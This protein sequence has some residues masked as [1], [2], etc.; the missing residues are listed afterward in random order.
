M[1][2]LGCETRCG[3]S[4]RACA[5][6]AAAPAVQQE[7][8]LLQFELRRRRVVELRRCDVNSADMAT[9]RGPFNVVRPPR[10]PPVYRSASAHTC[11]QPR[12][13]RRR[14]LT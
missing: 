3:L 6:D 5:E 11:G 4:Q 9:S 2:M 12:H 1:W 8:A 13:G 14:S 10:H 7:C